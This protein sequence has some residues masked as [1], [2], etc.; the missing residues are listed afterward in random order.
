MLILA[1]FA[2]CLVFQPKAHSEVKEVRRVV[3]FYELGPSSPAVALLDRE[4][5]AVL[6]N[7][8]LPHRII[9][10]LPRDNAL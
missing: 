10:R 3:V 1:L 4:M 5:R 7:S 8:P 2:A 6:E 9:W